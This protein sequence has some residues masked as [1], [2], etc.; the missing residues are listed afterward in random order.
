MLVQRTG[1][2]DIFDFEPI[3]IGLHTTQDNG[4]QTDGGSHTGF[5]GTGIMVLVDVFR[6]VGRIWAGPVSPK[7]KTFSFSPKFR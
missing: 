3:D 1:Q 7:N 5:R 6:R 4:R 2:A